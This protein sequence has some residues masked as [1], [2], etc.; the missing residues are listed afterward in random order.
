MIFKIITTAMRNELFTGQINI[1]TE[2]AKNA[3]KQ[4]SLQ[5][6]RLKFL[7]H[8]EN[9]TFKLSTEQ[10]NFLLRVYCGL[11]NTTQDIESEAKIIEYLNSCS[12]YSYQKPIRNISDRFVSIGEYR[13]ISKPVSILSWIDSPIVGDNINDLNLFEQLGKLLAEIHNKLSDWQKPVNFHRPMLDADALIGKHGAFGYAN[14]A[15]KYF[16]KE[17]VDLFESVYKRLINFEAVAGQGKNIFG[18]IHG[19][20]HLNN[21]ILHKNNL[22]PIDFDDSGYGYYIYDLAV[23]L[24][25]YWGM[26]EYSQIKT[27][28]I[29]GYRTI[30]KFSDEIENKLLLFIAARYI[31]I[32]LFLAGKSEQESGFKETASK[33][34]PFYIAKLKDIIPYV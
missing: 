1:N 4:Y 11:N 19:D 18:I 12:Q 29:Q 2:I 15:Y 33:Y 28:L 24:A 16:D 6:P 30:R 10:G 7:K 13:G 8:L 32:A 27:N 14:S 25:N 34:I 21:V 9:T 22:I 26:K 17:T 3:I 5:S 23:I 31:C 20:L